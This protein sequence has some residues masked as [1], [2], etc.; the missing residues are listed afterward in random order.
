LQTALQGKVQASAYFHRH[1]CSRNTVFTVRGRC[2]AWYS[3]RDKYYAPY[4]FDDIRLQEAPD[5]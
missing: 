5:A 3:G 2:S 1:P 4:T